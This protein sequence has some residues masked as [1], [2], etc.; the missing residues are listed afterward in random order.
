MFNNA[1]F[2]SALNKQ[3]AQIQQAQLQQTRL[4]HSHLQ[5]QQAALFNQGGTQTKRPQQ[6]VKDSDIQNQ[7]AVA[8]DTGTR[9]S[10]GVDMDSRGNFGP[11]DQNVT[12]EDK[13]P[14]KCVKSVTVV[15]GRRASCKDALLFEDHFDQPRID[16][17]KW[18]VEHRIPTYISPASTTHSYRC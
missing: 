6:S 18:I 16:P 9:G 3:Q 11:E 17:S 2:V 4:Q 10:F 1:D 8:P 13:N 12:A 14:K 15:N 7:E 5:Q